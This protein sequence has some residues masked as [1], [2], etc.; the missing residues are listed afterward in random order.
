MNS[1][2]FVSF[3]VNIIFSQIIHN[4]SLNINSQKLLQSA[5]SQISFKNLIIVGFGVAFTAK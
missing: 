3:E 1:S 4:F 5:P 2:A